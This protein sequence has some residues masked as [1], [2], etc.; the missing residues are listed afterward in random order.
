MIGVML[1]AAALIVYLAIYYLAFHVYDELWSPIMGGLIALLNL[2]LGTVILIAIWQELFT[3]HPAFVLDK[4]E[5]ACSASHREPTT[6]YVKSGNVMIP[7][8]SHHTVCDL[9]ARKP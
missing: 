7:V 8:T 2:T 5:W 6:T 9:Y 3:D 4:R 1:F